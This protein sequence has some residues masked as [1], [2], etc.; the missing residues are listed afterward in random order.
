M[1]LFA[2]AVVSFAILTAPTKTAELDFQQGDWTYNV[3]HA[4]IVEVDVIDGRHVT[5]TA[6][7]EGTTLVA[8]TNTNGT[9]RDYYVTVSGGGIWVDAFHED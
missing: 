1:T 5:F 7:K 8:F 3:E 4:S 2:V 9:Q 6:K